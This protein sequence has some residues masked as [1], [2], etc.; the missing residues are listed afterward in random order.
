MK[1][2]T[3][4]WFKFNEISNKLA[5]ELGRSKNIVG[6]YGE[7]LAHQYYKGKLLGVSK[8]GLDI[9]ATDGKRYQVK[10][11]KTN[12]LSTTQ[13]SILR[14]WEF[15]FLIVILFDSYGNI[16]KALEVPVDV[17]KEYS[18]ANPHRNGWL[19]TTTQNFLSNKRSR[20]ITDN[21]AEY[22]IL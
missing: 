5:T 20:D 17:A 1:T 6:E 3:E 16:S 13:L 22:N 12:K 9:I 10:S 8:K 7:Y 21:L 18:V 15:D 4:L 11:R 14:S 19:I 2:I